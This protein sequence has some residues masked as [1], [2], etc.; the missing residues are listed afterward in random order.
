M[1]VLCDYKY[2][3]KGFL[4]TVIEPILNVL[5][6]PESIEVIGNTDWTY[7]WLQFDRC[8][9][10]SSWECFYFFTHDWITLCCHISVR[11]HCSI[12]LRHIHATSFPR[13]IARAF[14]LI[15]FSSLS[16]PRASHMLTTLFLRRLL[17]ILRLSLQQKILC[18]ASGLKTVTW[19]FWK[20]WSPERLMWLHTVR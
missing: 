10:R 5:S 8:Q 15:S 11:A 14:P 9:P 7:W 6:P 3:E 12:F 4:K 16:L 17:G 20:G 19:W 13:V 1:C 2:V 18:S